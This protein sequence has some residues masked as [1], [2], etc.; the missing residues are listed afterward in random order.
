MVDRIAYDKNG[1]APRERIATVVRSTRLATA[2]LVLR[3]DS[4]LGRLGPIHVHDVDFTLPLG[5]EPDRLTWDQWHDSYGVVIGTH[6][7]LFERCRFHHLGDGA[8][9]QGARWEFRDCWFDEC[10]DDA[11]E[12]D[13]LTHGT[14]EGCVMDGVHVGISSR[15]NRINA[16]PGAVIAIR[17]TA[18]RLRPQVQSYKPWKYNHSARLETPPPDWPAGWQPKD[19]QGQHG[20]F[21]KF[22]PT[23]PQVY[24]ED[25]TLA[26]SQDCSYGGTLGPPP[27]V[28][29][30]SVTLIGTEAWPAEDVV[31]WE[32]S[33]VTVRYGTWDDWDAL[34]ARPHPASPQGA[35]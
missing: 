2:G 25:V 28:I 16:A 8:S 31:A 7:P 14:I 22:Q 29:G 10:Y 35:T 19:P 5:Y 17:R 6:D 18:I 1:T 23:S 3:A 11:I 15:N 33:P 13:S 24:L 20:P 32:Q 34:I 26:A 27:T 4:T 21:F 9:V 30:G 12:A